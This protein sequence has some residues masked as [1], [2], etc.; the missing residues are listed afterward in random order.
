MVSAPKCSSIDNS[1][2]T[3]AATVREQSSCWLR[4]S[5]LDDFVVL[6]RLLV[7]CT[8][9]LPPPV[10]RDWTLAALVIGSSVFALVQAPELRYI[11]LV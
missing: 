6:V 3:V 1:H 2:I 9:L 8:H 4:R 10:C 11:L 5:Q 7:A